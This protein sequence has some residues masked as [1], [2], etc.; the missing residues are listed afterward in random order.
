MV[1]GYNYS[2]VDCTVN[3][4]A[5]KGYQQDRQVSRFNSDRLKEGTFIFYV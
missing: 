2:R 1:V 3:F 4:K 5:I